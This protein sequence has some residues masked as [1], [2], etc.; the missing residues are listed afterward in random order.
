VSARRWAAGVSLLGLLAAAWPSG[1][2][3]QVGLG[4]GRR[5]VPDGD[6]G[7]PVTFGAACTACGDFCVLPGDFPGSCDASLACVSTTVT[8]AAPG[9]EGDAC[10]LLC[11]RCFGDPECD[12]EP[13][14]CQADGTCIDV[15][16]DCPSPACAGQ[17][18]GTA[19]D[20]CPPG[21]STCRPPVDLFVCDAGSAC[22]PAI[23]VKC[24]PCVALAQEKLKCGE[25]CSLCPPWDA[26]CTPDPGT[27]VCGA[28]GS[29][30]PPAQLTE[31]SPGYEPC[32]PDAACGQPCSVCDPLDVASCAVTPNLF[33]TGPNG[34]CTDQPVL[35]EETVCDGLACGA[36]CGFCWPS[37]TG[38]EQKFCDG[39]GAC[40]PAP[41]DVDCPG[42][43]PCDTKGCGDPCQLCDPSLGACD[44]QGLFLVCSVDG[45]GD[46]TD[47]GLCYAPCGGKACG[48]WC[49]D[50]CDPLYDPGCAPSVYKTC[51]AGGSCVENAP[52][53]L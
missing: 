10:G 42:A 45:C 17:L 16:P 11:D 46:A 1:C 34:A 7:G 27:H 48:E 22:R 4:T 24:E 40:M 36:Q 2:G 9:C 18:C 21:D 29:C 35:C 12:E 44:T 25:P 39:N 13:G 6:G 15:A 50:D 41:L 19:C 37:D 52:P 5:P 47:N 31:C 3:E 28:D 33:C 43:D 32:G 53:C 8:C 49:A 20:P 30:L 38:C 14:F 26:S 51:D 23:E